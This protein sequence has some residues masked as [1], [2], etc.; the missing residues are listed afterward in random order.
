VLCSRQIIVGV[1]QLLYSS[2]LY[3][4]TKSASDYLRQM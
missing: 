1:T 2:Q 3:S 4:S